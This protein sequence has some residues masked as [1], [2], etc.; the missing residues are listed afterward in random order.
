VKNRATSKRFAIA[1]VYLAAAAILLAC[2]RKEADPLV[3]LIEAAEKMPRRLVT[4]R[5]H[6][7]GYAPPPDETR[8]AS[9]EKALPGH[10]RLRAA[11]ISL[12]QQST[13]G[14][15]PIRGLAGVAALAN[16]DLDQ[17]V[18]LLRVACADQPKDAACWSNLSAA[19]CE[20]GRHTSNPRLMVDALASADRALRLG[21]RDVAADA[22]FNRAVALESLSLRL[23]AITAYRRYVVIDPSSPWS[24]EARSR[25]AALQSPLGSKWETALEQLRIASQRGDLD[26]IK[27]IAAQFPQRARAW[28]EGVFLGEWATASLERKSE[29]AAT[30]LTLARHVGLALKLRSGEALLA[31]AV[32]V[33]DDAIRRGD[34]SRQQNLALG[35]RAYAEG[36]IALSKGRPANAVPLLANAAQALRAGGSPMNLMASCYEASARF[37]EDRDEA[38]AAWK[39]L[40]ASVPQMYR[41]LTAQ[42]LWLR[43]TAVGT[44]G[45]LADAAAMYEEASRRFQ[46]LGELE[47]AA[48]T[49]SFAAHPLSR[50][51]QPTAAW[52]MHAQ[53]F[54]AADAE[55]AALLGTVVSEA[56]LSEVAQQNWP[57][58]DALF[59]VLAEMPRDS[60]PRRASDAWRWIA[61]ARWRSGLQSD[62]SSALAEAKHVADSLKSEALR[63]SAQ[64][65]IDVVQALMVQASKPA[66]ATA[67]LTGA[68]AFA[69]QHGDHVTL[70]NLYYQRALAE[71]RS[72]RG[73]EARSDLVTAVR[74][75]EEARTSIAADEVRDT[76]LGTVDEIYRELADL[77]DASGDTPEAFVVVE[78]RR[79]RLLLDRL[80]GARTSST[81]RLDA[82]L[83]RP[84]TMIE[85]VVLRDRVVI[86]TFGPAGWSRDESKREAQSIEHSAAALREAIEGNDAASIRRVATDLYGLLIAPIRH[87]FGS[88]PTLV[89]VPDAAIDGIPFAVL[90]DPLTGRYLAE[91]YTIVQAPS[92]S[93]YVRMNARPRRA[94]SGRGVVVADPAF[95]ASAFPALSRLPASRREIRAIATHA[96]PQ[97]LMDERATPSRVLDALAEADFVQISAHTV[98]N[99]ADPA[100]SALVLSPEPHRTGLLYVRDIIA[101]HTDAELVALIGCQ[102]AV[103]KTT[104]AISSLANGFLSAGS[105]NVVATLFDIDDEVALRFSE[106]LHVQLAGGRTPAEAVRAA[107]L[108]ML[109]SADPLLR[110]PKSWAAFQAYGLGR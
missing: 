54:A 103:T 106:L 38:A 109:Q 43:A 69:E 28:G 14:S 80:A 7:F 39:R 97:I 48:T 35:Q 87:H 51:G 32:A 83:Q 33:I 91:D 5:L 79:G 55:S 89:I 24:I 11:A 90:S 92:I 74:M 76:Y 12:L 84:E 53:A 16:G 82:V 15:G 50:L 67:L 27:A 105:R 68:I 13:E 110:Q 66:E 93:T 98:L 9:D 56:A 47:N 1:K 3:P 94:K 107:Q 41:A 31:D 26:S 99:V 17:S 104:G 59:S 42:L 25:A 45:M 101:A 70:P 29:A 58:A 49:A 65:D 21:R 2:S 108:Q 96:A 95:D 86:Y 78:R 71:R 102:T 8:L 81:L 77:L 18:R 85:F 57:A 23:P 30:A 4:G 34:S 10:W 88:Q 6:S 73:A 22:A 61:F 52:R 72:G 62:A 37:D 60:S 40:S 64:H 36:R 75:V 20:L 19:L 46:A 63:E 100:A 44:A